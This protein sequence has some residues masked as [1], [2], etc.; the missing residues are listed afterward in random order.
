M[1]PIKY[2]SEYKTGPETSLPSLYQSWIS[3]IMYLLHGWLHGYSW[4]KDADGMSSVVISLQTT[5]MDAS[6][7]W[8]CSG[9]PSNHSLHFFS[10]PCT[11]PKQRGTPMHSDDSQ[12]FLSLKSTDSTFRER[13]EGCSKVAQAQQLPKLADFLPSH[14]YSFDIFF[15]FFCFGSLFGLLY[16]RPRNLGPESCWSEDGPLWYL[17]RVAAGVSKRWTVMSVCNGLWLRGPHCL[18]A[19]AE[20]HPAG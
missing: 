15:V 5:L 6:Q 16:S 8:Q 12:L 7:G 2:S 4:N 13:K 3:D 19:G 18:Y 10:P 9:W 11:Q 17:L 20:A 14:G 1:L